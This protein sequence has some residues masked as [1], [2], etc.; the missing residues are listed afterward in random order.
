[1]NIAVMYGLKEFLKLVMHHTNKNLLMVLVS[2]KQLY[3]LSLILI[4][5][6]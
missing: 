2:R 4:I 3:S 5:K 6:E 1:M